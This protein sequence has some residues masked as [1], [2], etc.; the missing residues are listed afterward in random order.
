[1]NYH[2]MLPVV[3]EWVLWLL[4]LL[5]PLVA[6]CTLTAFI[7]L[8][9]ERKTATPEKNRLNLIMASSAGLLTLLILGFMLHSGLRIEEN[10]ANATQN[11]M[12]KYD[13][14]SVEWTTP[15]NRKTN[16]TDTVSDRVVM[17]TD[18]DN[19]VSVF[20]YTTNPDTSAPRLEDNVDET[21]NDSFRRIPADT[22]LKK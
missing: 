13:I 4:T 18:R 16:P 12:T 1:M 17:V 5:T 22:L 15:D 9:R 3:D 14:T 21:V 19:N 6:L 10:R 7:V 2:Q 11:I 20:N 8:H